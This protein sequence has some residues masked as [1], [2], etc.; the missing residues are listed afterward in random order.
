M[1]KSLFCKHQYHINLISVKN[2][3]SAFDADIKYKITY[4]AIC[5]ICNKVKINS[6]NIKSDEELVN[7]AQLSDEHLHGVN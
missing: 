7:C 3:K 2:H 1:F 6:F 4:N 5:T